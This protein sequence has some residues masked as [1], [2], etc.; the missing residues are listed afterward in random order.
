MHRLSLAVPESVQPAPWCSSEQYTGTVT[1]M[2][3]TRVIAIILLFIG[4]SIAVSLFV[5]R[6]QIDSTSTDTT[7]TS[8]NGQSAVTQDGEIKTVEIEIDVDIVDAEEPGIFRLKQGDRVQL[9]VTGDEPHQVEVSGYDLIEPV[10]SRVSA[11]FDFIAN[12]SG[13]HDIGLL[14]SSKVI[15]VLSVRESG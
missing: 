3:R 14:E 4:V 13:R 5:P 7:R 12:V 1:T 15:G 2:S 9:T 10:S 8:T 11:R 6:G